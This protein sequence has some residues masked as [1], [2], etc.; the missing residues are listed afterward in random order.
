M[1]KTFYI[2]VTETFNRVV[3]AGYNKSTDFE[4]VK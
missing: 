2:S 1:K 3:K 4:E